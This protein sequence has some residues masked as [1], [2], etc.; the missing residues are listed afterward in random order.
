MVRPSGP[1]RASGTARELVRKEREKEKVTVVKVAR[2][3]GLK[4]L[5]TRFAI[6][7][8]A[9]TVTSAATA[10]RLKILVEHL[11]VL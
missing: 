5:A 11:Q 8:S 2:V 3:T 1:Q 6:L 4:D 7:A 10:T 9:S